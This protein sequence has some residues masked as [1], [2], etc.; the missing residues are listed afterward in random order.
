MLKCLVLCVEGNGG[1][2]KWK[3]TINLQELISNTDYDHRNVGAFRKAISK[4][5]A[6]GSAD[7][8]VTLNLYNNFL[9]QIEAAKQLRDGGLGAFD[10]QKL[11][12]M[13][14]AMESAEVVLPSVVR[15]NL[16]ERHSNI[17]A[18]QKRWPEL[19]SCIN[20]FGSTTWNPAEPSLSAIE[21]ASIEGRLSTFQ[22]TLFT[23]ALS[24]LVLSGQ[25][26]ETQ[27]AHLIEVAHREFSSI[28]SLDV[29]E[30]V[31]AA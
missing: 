4:L 30:A 27:L 2:A 25:Q 6:K 11:N 17:L 14:Q 8:M 19:M 1:I 12:T 5:Q 23:I 20:P 7:V 15:C 22:N 28:D 18:S 10:D 26:T 31:A 13:L 24:P 3:S 29:E 16:V 9:D 21:D